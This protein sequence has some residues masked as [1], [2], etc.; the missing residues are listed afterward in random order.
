M[1]SAVPE[2]TR[3]FQRLFHVATIVT[4]HESVCRRVLTRLLLPTLPAP[5]EEPSIEKES[6]E[7]CFIV[8][9]CRRAWVALESEER[10]RLTPLTG[11]ET[12]VVS[13]SQSIR[14]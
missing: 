8:Q 2:Q 7:A 14:L 10:F 5:N 12:P 11:I 9:A 6:D 13:S 4:T 1:I 3:L